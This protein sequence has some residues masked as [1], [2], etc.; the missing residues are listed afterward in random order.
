MNQLQK[1]NFTEG[2]ILGPLLRFAAPVLGARILQ[3]MYGAVDL[4][5]VGKYAETADVSAVASGTQIMNTVT[6]IIM[7]IS[8]GITVLIGQ[9][10][11]AGRSSESGR[12]IAAGIKLFAAFG[13]VLC[14]AIV[15][16]RGQICTLLHC[17]PEAFSRSM[18]YIGI[19]GAGIYF[20]IFYNVLGSVFR[21]MGDSK[22]PLLSVAIACAL[23]IAGDVAF[24]RYLGLGASGAALATVMSQGVS[25]IV[26]AAIIMKRGLPFEF[27]R[28]SFRDTGVLTRNILE[29]GV[30]VAL[31]D[32]VVGLSFLILTS[33]TNNIGLIE[34][35]GVGVAEKVCSFV[36]LVPSAFSQAVTAFVAQNIGAGK[37]DRASLALRY[38]ISVSLCIG[39]VISWYSFF[40]GYE[41][42][43]I[44]SSDAAV[45]AAGWDNLKAYAIDVLLTS[46]LFCFLGYFNGC[47]YTRMT[48]L[49][50]IGSAFLIRVPISYI[51]SKQIPVSLFRIGLATPCASAAQIL[52]CF[53]YY[54]RKNKE[55]KRAGAL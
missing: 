30:P 12:I 9:S 25:V 16:L 48:M 8:M 51:M 14:A 55:A 7:G 40:R 17:P 4:M 33:I 13:A 36:M 2:K 21:G 1:N 19:C 32:F 52:V 6:G 10:I 27:G 47:G 45:V 29:I 20:I 46:F 37:R 24:V 35:A 5:V 53:W 31:Q 42:T 3:A 11:G 41:L 54:H 39:V 44:F 23:N 22:T 18:A 49:Q 38:S 26:C 28:K 34:S 15:L 43:G 50:G